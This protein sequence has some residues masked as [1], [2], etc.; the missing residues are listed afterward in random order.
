MLIIKTLKA[1]KKFYDLISITDGF[2]GNKIFNK[3]ARVSASRLL[4]SNQQYDKALL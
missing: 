4:L 1:L 3:L 2:N